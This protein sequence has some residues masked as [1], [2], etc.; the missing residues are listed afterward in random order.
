MNKSINLILALLL[1]AAPSIMLAQQRSL[2]QDKVEQAYKIEWIKQIPDPETR[3][4]TSA[5]RR[6]GEIVIGKREFTI[7]R[8]VATI[9]SSTG[10]NLILSQENGRIIS[11]DGASLS[12]LK[13][14]NSCKDVFPSLI[15]ACTL[16]SEE[17]LVTDSADDMI[18]R[19]DN[20]GIIKEFCEGEIL[21]RPTGIAYSA[22]TQTI[23]VAESGAHRLSVFNLA[24]KLIK[25]VGERGILPGQFNF[26]G[27]ICIDPEGLI[28]VVDAMNFR[29]QVLDK[30]GEY[31]TSFGKHGDASG[32][33]SRPKGI[34]IDSPGNIYIA[35]ALSNTVQIFNKNGDFL[36]YFGKKGS[37][38]GEFLMPAG[39]S[40]DK[41]DY[42]YVSDSYNNRI[43]VFRAVK[44]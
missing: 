7:S 40:I 21:K 14:K 19:I 23:W 12:Y 31:L 9:F 43:Q 33:F 8:P 2:N 27:H 11:L 24:G 32:S 30:N 34:A 42:I 10:L 35:D 13:N 16:G 28:Y 25:R 20:K 5:W 29:V 1:L 18:Y 4:K 37:G 17:V 41:N 26:P 38:K 15:S 39:I 44:K 22:L 3:K 6:L 36:F